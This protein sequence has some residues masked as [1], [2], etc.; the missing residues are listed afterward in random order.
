M[1]A[2]TPNHPKRPQ[3]PRTQRPTGTQRGSGV[4]RRDESR[5]P[6]KEPRS[7]TPEA[8]KEAKTKAATSQNE[9]KLPYRIGLLVVTGLFI[10][11]GVGS[12][13]HTWWQQNREY[14]AVNS[15]LEQAKADRARLQAELSKWKTDSF[16]AGQARSR[17][18]YINPGESQYLV[19]DPPR[20]VGKPVDETKVKGPAR[21]WYLVITESAKA[22]AEAQLETDSTNPQPAAPAPEQKTGN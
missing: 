7:R 9:L 15:Q 16:L 21:P 5:R 12:P 18:G 8:H 20:S 11:V 19:V 4:K 2:E 17:L 13:I 1:T 10:L 3:L 22:A 14:N 6:R